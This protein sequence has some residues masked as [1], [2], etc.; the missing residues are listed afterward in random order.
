MIILNKLKLIV[1]LEFS[2]NFIP[3]NCEF[4]LSLL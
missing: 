1:D 2:L 3:L 4:I